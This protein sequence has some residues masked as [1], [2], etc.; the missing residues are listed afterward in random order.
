MY[1]D[2]VYEVNQDIAT[3]TINRANYGNSFSESTY[4]E[5]VEAMKQV[6]Q[7]PHVKVAIITGAG[8][9][10]CAGGDIQLFQELIAS[11]R[12]IA[13]EDVLMTGEMV[14]SV[15]MCR[16]PVISVV[17]GVAAG[18]G[19]GLV[20]ACDFIV[21]S[22]S[23]RLLTAFIDMAFPGDTILLY[24]L[25]TAIGSQRT[26]R[27]MMLNEP[28]DAELALEYGLAYQ[29]VA[30][31]DL[32]TSGFKLAKTL[33][34]KSSQALGYQKELFAAIQYPEA[35]RINKMEAIFMRQS[36]M[37]MD[38]QEAVSNFLKKSSLKAR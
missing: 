25:Q 7:D 13:E 9:N 32:M 20:L 17:N 26:I 5:I 33:A 21:M 34:T 15:K 28:I 1:Q 37:G 31:N 2:I 29:V 23:S 18:A 4:G 10:F 12:Y 22:H 27:H 8:K 16:K 38:H 6:D 3:I 19:F 35:E 24:N 30:E 11:E 14:R 36:S